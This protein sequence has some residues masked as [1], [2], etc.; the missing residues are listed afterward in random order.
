MNT[1]TM[2]SDLNN[3]SRAALWTG[4]IL[5]ALVVLALLADAGVSLFA[6]HLLARNM[7]ETGFPV[8]LSSVVGGIL[9]VSTVLYAIP[10]TSVLGAILLTGFLGGAICTHLR[11]GEM[12]SPPQIVSA[13]LGIAAW[14]ALYLRNGKVR[15][16]FPLTG[17][18]S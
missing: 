14:A 9:A 15:A 6:S 13:L 11:M 3:P 17:P 7:E 8:E 18:R 5:G 10:R 4:R 12:G 2:N 16:L 1:T